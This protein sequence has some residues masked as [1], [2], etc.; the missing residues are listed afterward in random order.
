MLALLVAMGCR[1][2]EGSAA[3]PAPVPATTLPC[4]ARTGQYRWKL[5]QRDGDCGPV[6]EMVSGAPGQPMAP[7]CTSAVP[8]P[9]PD[10]CRVEI[11]ST[12]PVDAVTMMRIAGVLQYS[13]DGSSGAGLIQFTLVRNGAL[14]CTGTYD[15]SV[16][17]L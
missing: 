8:A 13:A 2:F 14:Y 1:E 5:T 6:S 17:R 15:V 9:A 3:R 4:A 12:C 10:A 16:S 7:G 11:N